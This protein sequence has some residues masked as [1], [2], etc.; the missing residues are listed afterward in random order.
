MAS[1]RWF[2]YRSSNPVCS[3]LI[4]FPSRARLHNEKILAQNLRL[5]KWHR[6][7]LAMMYPTLAH[8][9]AHCTISNDPEAFQ[10]VP[11]LTLNR[12][13]CGSGVFNIR[14]QALFRHLFII[15][16]RVY[17][18]VLYCESNG[19]PKFVSPVRFWSGRVCWN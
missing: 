1:P 3:F 8:Q 17:T 7:I 13:E 4:N 19:F 18:F 2:L 16:L 6:A 10:R 5:P 15:R 9:G 14:Q 12:Y 11:L